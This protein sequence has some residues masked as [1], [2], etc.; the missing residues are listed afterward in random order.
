MYVYSEDLE[1]CNTSPYGKEVALLFGSWLVSELQVLLEQVT[2]SVP[3][4][5]LHRAELR[6]VHLLH[7]ISRLFLIRVVVFSWGY[8]IFVFVLLYK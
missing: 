7:D 6:I 3:V 8:Q 2:E 1:T 4:L 5:Q